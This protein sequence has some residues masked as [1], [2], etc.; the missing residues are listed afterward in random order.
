MKELMRHRE[1]VV[2]RMM[3][4]EAE[5][6]KMLEILRAAPVTVGR[7]RKNVQGAKTERRN[8]SE[9]EHAGDEV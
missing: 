6:K 3:E 4:V 2:R 8:G 7:K 1:A 9:L 5:L